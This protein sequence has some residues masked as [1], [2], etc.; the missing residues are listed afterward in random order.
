MPI[1]WS[2][3][4]ALGHPQIDHDHRVLVDMLNRVETQ[5][6]TGASSS[7]VEEVLVGLNN[8]VAEHF[9]REEGIMEESGYSMIDSHKGQHQRFTTQIKKLTANYQDDPNA[10]DLP[11]LHKFLT[12]WLLTHIQITDQ[13]LVS[14]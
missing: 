12:D 3:D 14:G 11:K 2:Q 9:A 5:I 4:L 1:Q 7:D 13:T 10:I 8:Y 6:E